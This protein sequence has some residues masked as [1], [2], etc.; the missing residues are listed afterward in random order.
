[1]SINLYHKIRDGKKEKLMIMNFEVEI[2]AILSGVDESIISNLKLC[3]NYSIK[4][5][6]LTNSELYSKF[7]YT[8]LGIKKTYEDSKLNDN[9]DIALLSKTFQIEILSDISENCDVLH[10]IEEKE[11]NTKVEK[12][13]NLNELKRNIMFE[14]IDSIKICEDGRITVKYKK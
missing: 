12:Y 4:R 2:N 7:D 14:I 9:L 5:D 13:K 11:I 1:M 3:N 6:S 8:V 10:D